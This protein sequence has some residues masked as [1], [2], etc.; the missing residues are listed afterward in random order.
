[1]SELKKGIIVVGL[2]YF[3]LKLRPAA[4]SNTE[5]PQE[6]QADIPNTPVYA[7]ISNIGDAPAI[8]V[9]V[10]NNGRLNM[11]QVGNFLVP[12]DMY[13]LYERRMATN[14]QWIGDILATSWSEYQ[15]AW[16]TRGVFDGVIK[17]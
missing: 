15:R 9:E 16:N 10:S 4:A 17:L 5:T 3:L 14:P 13:V 11:V 1:M 12:A 2:I 8:Q 7:Q 6:A